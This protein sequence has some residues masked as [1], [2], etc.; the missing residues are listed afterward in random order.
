MSII[1]NEKKKLNILLEQNL[2]NSFVVQYNIV[3][4]LPTFPNF[5]GKKLQILT[6]KRFLKV[7]FSYDESVINYNLKKIIK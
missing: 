2:K 6:R 3:A 4:K 7:S 1:K 5:S